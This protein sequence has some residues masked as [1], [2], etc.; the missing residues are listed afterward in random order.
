MPFKQCN[1]PDVKTTFPNFDTVFSFSNLTKKVLSLTQASI[2]QK[3]MCRV[4]ELDVEHP[5]CVPARQSEVGNSTGGLG[6]SHDSA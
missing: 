6:P 1:S 2:T 5:C 4:T 3:V